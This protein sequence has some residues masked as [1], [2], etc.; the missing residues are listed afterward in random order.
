MMSDEEL[1]CIKCGA[2]AEQVG[3]KYDFDSEI[4]YYKCPECGHK[5]TKIKLE[6]DAENE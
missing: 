4:I 3:S 2:I 5:F 1:V 6:T